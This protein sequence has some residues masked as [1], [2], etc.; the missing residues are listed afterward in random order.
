MG[1]SVTK[2]SNNM[3]SIYISVCDRTR[4]GIM[5]PIL[6]YSK[7]IEIKSDENEGYET[8]TPFNGEL[9]NHLKKSITRTV[10]RNEINILM[11]QIENVWSLP[12]AQSM[13]DEVYQGM[14]L[15]IE[16]NNNIFMNGKP[17][18]CVH[19]APSLKVTQTQ[20]NIYNTIIDKIVNY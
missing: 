10:T 14:T 11:A 4:G 17:C 5:A 8:I 12:S 1:S 3:E 7:I 6:K 13:D 18:G 19:N 20:Q 15:Y 2:E 9:S 16:Y